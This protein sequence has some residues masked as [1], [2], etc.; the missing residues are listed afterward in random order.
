VFVRHQLTTD[1]DNG[2]LYW[3]DSI[4]VN[5]DDLGFQVKDKFANYRGRKNVNERTR[6]A[7]EDDLFQIAVDAS[8]GVVDD[9]LGSQ[10]TGFSDEKHVPNKVTVRFHPIF[11]DRFVTFFRP[12]MQ[13][14]LNGLDHTIYGEIVD[15]I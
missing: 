4:G 12:G 14:P 6:Q 5:M 7:A 13:V 3:E 8:Q 15:L 1:T 9:I 10:I 11:K 2:I